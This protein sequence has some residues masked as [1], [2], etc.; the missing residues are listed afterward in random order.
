LCFGWTTALRRSLIRSNSSASLV[1]SMESRPKRAGNTDAK[2]PPIDS[3]SICEALRVVVLPFLSVRSYSRSGP[4]ISEQNAS[5]AD[6]AA[7]TAL[8][9]SRIASLTRN[10]S[11][12]RSWPGGILASCRSIVS[13]RWV[14]RASSSRAGEEEEDRGKR[15]V[16]PDLTESRK[17][18]RRQ[19]HKHVSGFDA[20]NRLRD[21]RAPKPPVELLG[22]AAPLPTSALGL[23]H[24]GSVRGGSERLA[25]VPPDCCYRVCIPH[26]QSYIARTPLAR[27]EEE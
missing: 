24:A 11:G 3:H 6:M 21:H 2:R 20:R 17:L 27:A 16:E 26:G 18:D 14:A 12:L 19:N 23:R 22:R 9:P 15:F 5:S 10:G 7:T 13:R 1:P 4:T 25:G 8:A